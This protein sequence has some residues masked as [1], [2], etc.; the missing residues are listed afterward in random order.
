MRKLW[1]EIGSDRDLPTA[2]GGD[3]HVQWEIPLRTA[4]PAATMPAIGQVCRA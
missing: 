4:R 3:I 2:V 1:T